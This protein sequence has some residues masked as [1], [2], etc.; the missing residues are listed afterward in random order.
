MVNTMRWYSWFSLLVG[1]SSLTLI[2]AYWEA[3]RDRIENPKDSDNNC[4]L[5]CKKMP[6]YINWRVGMNQIERDGLVD[7]IS[8]T[9]Y[10][11]VEGRSVPGLHDTSTFVT[12]YLGIPYAEPPVDELRFKVGHL[13]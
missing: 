2:S 9:E 10:G 6:P 12:M 11:A 1:F 7:V 4:D 13:A 5:Y 3:E 8:A